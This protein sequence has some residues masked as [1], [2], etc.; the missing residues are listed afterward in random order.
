MKWLRSRQRM[1]GPSQIGRNGGGEGRAS[2]VSRF[3]KRAEGDGWTSGVGRQYRA[4][5]GVCSGQ[6]RLV[7][8][9]FAITISITFKLGRF[10][11]NQAAGDGP[12]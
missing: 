12:P 5:M 6:I 2:F 1:W 11:A 7:A 8:T 3:A 4:Q 10:A 9:S